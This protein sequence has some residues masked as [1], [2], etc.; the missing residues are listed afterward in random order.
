[1]SALSIL[2][3]SL[4][5]KQ[6]YLAGNIGLCMQMTSDSNYNLLWRV[7]SIVG[8]P[9]L[10]LELVPRPLHWINIGP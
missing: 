9:Q 6:N 2:N 8:K 5:I 3:L 4:R 10:L 7:Y 1:M